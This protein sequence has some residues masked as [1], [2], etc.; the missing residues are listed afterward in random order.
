MTLRS[1]RCRTTSQRRESSKVDL[2]SKA[3]L[4]ERML[5]LIS[6]DP[7]LI[8]QLLLFSIIIIPN[9]RLRKGMNGIKF[10]SFKHGDLL[11]M[12]QIPRN[13]R[14]GTSSSIKRR[15]ANRRSI[16][17]FVVIVEQDFRNNIKVLRTLKVLLSIIKTI[18]NLI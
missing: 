5:M 15:R 3:L 7:G 4:V 16:V 18:L 13:L 9:T 12:S 6:A 11:L 17:V 8:A 1:R 2:V 14:G 10:A